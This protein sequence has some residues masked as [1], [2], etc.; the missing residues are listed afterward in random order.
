VPQAYGAARYGTRVIWLKLD[1]LN[2]DLQQVKKKHPP[3]GSPGP[4]PLAAVVAVAV[5]VIGALEWLLARIWWVIGGTAVLIAVAGVVALSRWTDRREVS[6]AERRRLHLAAAELSPI[7]RRRRSMPHP[8]RSSQAARTSGLPGYQTPSRPPSS[9]KRSS[10][11][12]G[13]PPPKGSIVQDRTH[14][15]RRDRR[16][17]GRP[18]RRPSPDTRVVG[19]RSRTP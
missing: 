4:G 14:R 11:R 6:F 18:S 15:R 2:P 8:T 13:K 12:P 16:A 19:R 7:P 10:D 17:R 1:C 3:T 5:V 9:A